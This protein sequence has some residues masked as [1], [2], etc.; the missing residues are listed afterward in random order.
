MLTSNPTQ[1]AAALATTRAQFAGGPLA[2][3]SG[4]LAH[5]GAPTFRSICK[6]GTYSPSVRRTPPVTYTAVDMDRI[7]KVAEALPAAAAAGAAG[8]GG[9]PTHAAFAV[10][11]EIYGDIRVKQLRNIAT[12]EFVEVMVRTEAKTP[13]PSSSMCTPSTTP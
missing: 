11:D 2:L 4:I 3:A 8:G 7:N 9:G 13:P 1:D 10:L 5:P 6:S 12:G